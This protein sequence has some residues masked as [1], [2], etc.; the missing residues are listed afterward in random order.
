MIGCPEIPC[1]ASRPQ[2]VL[3]QSLQPDRDLV[4]AFGG[5]EQHAAL[6]DDFPAREWQAGHDRSRRGQAR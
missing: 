6:P 2:L 3:D 1:I 4:G 5:D